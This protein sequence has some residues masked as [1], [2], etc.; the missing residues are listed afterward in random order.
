[1]DTSKF[2]LQLI[3]RLL[4]IYVAGILGKLG[5]SEAEAGNII[6]GLAAILTSVLIAVGVYLWAAI[7]R[8][9]AIDKALKTPAPSEGTDK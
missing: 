4:S 7:E 9:F 3:T 8:R 5:F 1:V 6:T 2:L